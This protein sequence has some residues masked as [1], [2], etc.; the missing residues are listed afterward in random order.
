V[1]RELGPIAFPELEALKAQA[2]AARTYAIANFAKRQAGGYNLLA[3][4][5]D[6]V[7]GG[8]QDEHPLST[9]AVNETEG[10]IATADGERPID[11]LYFSTSGGFTANNEDVFNSN[12]VAYLRGIPDHQRESSLDNHDDGVQN[13]ANARSLRAT[14][15]GDF[16]ADWSRYH[17]WTFDWS[18]AEIRDVLSSWV[19]DDVGTVLEI[20]VLE[21]SGSGR[22]KT[23]EYVTEAG[24]F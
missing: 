15:S 6:Q 13:N 2:V 8:Y 21:R 19:G 18:A 11:A 1:P 24:R 9:R 22:V 17:R 3:T 14:R 5:A 23:I 4:T 10:L 7:Y 12:P 16:E 20:N